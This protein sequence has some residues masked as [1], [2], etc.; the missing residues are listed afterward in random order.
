MVAAGLP[1]KRRFWRQLLAFD[2]SLR[3]I[4]NCAA[5]YALECFDARETGRGRSTILRLTPG[6]Y[7]YV[8]ELM[9]GVVKRVVSSKPAWPLETPPASFPA[10]ETL[11]WQPI[12]GF[13]HDVR[14]QSPLFRLLERSRLGR[15]LGQS[16]FPAPAS[17]ASHRRRPHRQRDPLLYSDRVQKRGRKAFGDPLR[18]RGRSAEASQPAALRSADPDRASEQH[19][20]FGRLRALTRFRRGCGGMEIGR[21]PDHFL[22]IC[23]VEELDRHEQG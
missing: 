22:S 12:D 9:I 14:D 15:R 13:A 19:F 1:R 23:T 6:V 10:G 8:G 16:F 21:D 3:R 17:R 18:S 7:A 20:E 5:P 4:P 2:R 11:D